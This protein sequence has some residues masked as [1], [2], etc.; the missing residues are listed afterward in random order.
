MDHVRIIGVP[1]DLGAGRRGVD[2][3]PSAIRYAF[4]KEKLER[5]VR[6]VTDHGNLNI[7]TLGAYSL[8]DLNAAMS[9]Y[10]LPMKYEEEIANACEQLAVVVKQA[11]SNQEFP[12]ILG[13]DHSIAMGSLAGIAH[14]HARKIGLIWIDAHGDLNTPET[15]PSGN[16]HGMPLAVALGH[17]TGRL[18]RMFS[19]QGMIEPKHLVLIGVRDLDQGE[20]DLIKELGIQVYTMHDI[21]REGISNIINESIRLV[22][23]GTDWVHLS[24]DMDGVDPQYAPGVGTPVAGGLS[25]REINLCMELLCAAKII[26]SM[27]VVEV[28][29]ILDE[30]NRTAELA[31]SLILALFGDTIL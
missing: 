9:K 11:I 17:G 7:P 25:Y 15:T 3:G 2:M 30:R 16:I 6:V 4:L 28:N 20:K 23:E 26:R 21:D 29:P 27:D 14:H 19:H 8:T 10:G 12:L 22:S 1:M 13:G 31:V 24:L 5:F 18:L